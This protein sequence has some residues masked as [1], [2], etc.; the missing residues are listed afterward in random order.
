VKYVKALTHFIQEHPP[1][2]LK[3]NK[4]QAGKGVNKKGYSIKEYKIYDKLKE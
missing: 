2:N 3:N 4:R 1:Q